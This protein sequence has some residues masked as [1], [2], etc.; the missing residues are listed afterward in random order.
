MENRPLRSLGLD[1]CTVDGR[2]WAEK[3]TGVQIRR[4]SSSGF[5]WPYEVVSVLVAAK[6]DQRS[7]RYGP[8]SFDVSWCEIQNN[9]KIYIGGWCTLLA[10]DEKTRDIPRV[11]SFNS[12]SMFHRLSDEKKM[13]NGP[14]G[15]SV[16]IASCWPSRVHGGRRIDR[17]KKWPVA[18]FTETPRKA[19]GDRTG[20]FRC[21]SD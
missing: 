12:M 20:T 17:R 13:G 6:N 21:L 4:N 2:R 8:V 15:S 3:M 10:A 14:R 9:H 11:A 16:K 7:P 18:K 5:L 19:F 1:V